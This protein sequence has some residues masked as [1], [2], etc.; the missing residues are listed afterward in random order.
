MDQ[1][2]VGFEPEQVL[3]GLKPVFT[4]VFEVRTKTPKSGGPERIGLRR[5]ISGRLCAEP[6]NRS[7]PKTLGNLLLSASPGKAESMARMRPGGGSANGYKRSL[8]VFLGGQA[9]FRPDPKALRGC[10]DTSSGPGPWRPSKPLPIRS[11]KAGWLWVPGTDRS[12][13]VTLPLPL[14]NAAF[15]E[16][17]DFRFRVA[18]FG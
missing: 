15:A 6:V 1:W 12:G 14:Q 13:A 5:A 7:A 16:S 4:W 3:T 17:G 9:G 11:I 10:P 18:R 2:Q 8:D